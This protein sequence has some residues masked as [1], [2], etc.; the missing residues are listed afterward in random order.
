MS[1]KTA[2]NARLKINRMINVIKE[3]NHLTAL[4]VRFTPPTIYIPTNWLLTVQR[5]HFTR[6]QEQTQK[7]NSSDNEEMKSF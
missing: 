1:V 5:A 2:I 7:L 3:I 4:I 6:K